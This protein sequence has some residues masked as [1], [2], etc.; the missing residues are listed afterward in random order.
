MHFKEK[1]EFEDRK[2]ESTRIKVK[3]PNRIPVIVERVKGCNNIPE[4]TKHKYLVPQDL[5]IGQLN[6]VIR[7]KIPELDAHVGMFI[8]INSQM[9][10]TGDII[11]LIY[12]KHMDED[13]FLYI[14]YSGENTFG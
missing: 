9:P 8:F 1:N 10:S 11:R 13:G 6:Y 7:K 14:E 4:I 2:A 3:Y 5:T 12:E